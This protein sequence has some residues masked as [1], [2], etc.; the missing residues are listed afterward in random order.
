MPDHARQFRGWSS[1]EN[2]YFRIFLNPTREINVKSHANENI[3]F[4]DFEFRNLRPTF[5]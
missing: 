5:Q 1:C 4:D 2:E 3:Y